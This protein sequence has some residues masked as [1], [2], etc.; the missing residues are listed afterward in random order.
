MTLWVNARSTGLLVSVSGA[1]R[2]ELVGIVSV[3]VDKGFRVDSVHSQFR[4]NRNV[5]VG[6]FAKECVVDTDDL[7]FL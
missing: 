2:T 7:L 3:T 5:V 1:R 4:V 6:K